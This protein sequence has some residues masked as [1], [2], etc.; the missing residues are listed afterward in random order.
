VARNLAASLDANKADKAVVEQVSSQLTDI[1]INIS[2]FPR[3][4]GETDD[5]PRFERAVSHLSSKGGG[6]LQ[7]RIE[8]YSLKSFTLPDN[9]ILKG[10]VNKGVWGTIKATIL[11]YTSNTG[12]FINVN[13]YYQKRAG[14]EDILIR[15]ST[16]L[17]TDP[18]TAIQIKRQTN[19]WGASAIIK[20]VAING[21]GVGIQHYV[22]YGSLVERCVIT[23]CGKG[24]S[25][26]S[27]VV[28][29]T[30]DAGTTFGN[31]NLI[32]ETTV[33]VCD[34]GIE[35]QSDTISEYRGGIIEQC[36][37]AI[38]YYKTSTAG[39]LPPQ[40]WVFNRVWFERNTKYILC[41]SAVD[42]TFNATGTQVVSELPEFKGCRNDFP[43][44]PQ[45]PSFN[46]NYETYTINNEPRLRRY[47][48]DDS[49]QNFYNK[50]TST[51]ERVQVGENGAWRTIFSLSNKGTTVKLGFNAYE[52]ST[53]HTTTGVTTQV[54]NI[55]YS[56]IIN[57]E[58]DGNA[59]HLSSMAL[60]SVVV[61]HN[62]G[63]ISNAVFVLNDF[64]KYA[65]VT[66]FQLGTSFSSYGGLLQGSG[67]T[68]SGATGNFPTDKTFNVNVNANIIKKVI[69]KINYL[70][71]GLLSE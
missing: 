65:P 47:P 23:E 60:M 35:I 53:S 32:D 30:Q 57:I 55:N 2:Q 58:Q 9:V 19:D 3:L 24:L 42:A 21:F 52:K 28:G 41:N 63:A 31:G 5:T 69:V 7:L 12:V 49:A 15:S 33:Y 22:A 48:T 39:F 70:P 56:D 62:D 61:I 71:N 67:I 37:I 64:A 11:T 34:I 13:S 16:G 44:N 17:R 66:A 1:A 38:Q 51:I 59:N 10:I 54:T 40:Q 43:P 27:E 46:S 6:T 26:K 29:A 8:E 36:K 45:I 68:V 14:I 50:P 25:Y 4:N 20:R 18:T